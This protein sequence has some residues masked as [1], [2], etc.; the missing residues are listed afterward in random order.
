WLLLLHQKVKAAV[1]AGRKIRIPGPAALT[2]AFNA[3]FEG[4]V[5]QDEHGADLSPREAREEQ[6]IKGKI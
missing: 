2:L 1:E 4:R 5:L 6:S 3:F